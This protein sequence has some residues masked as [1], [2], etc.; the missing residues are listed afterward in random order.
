MQSHFRY[1]RR[2]DGIV[3]V[4]MDWPDS[5]V[6]LMDRQFNPALEALLT[7]LEAERE[8]T[9]GVI[10]TSAKTSFF[11]GADLKWLAGFE[12]DAAAEAFAL[13]ERTKALFRRIEL[14]GK[15]VVAVINGSALGAGWEIALACHHRVIV[16]SSDIRVGLPEVTLGLLPG[17]GGITRMVRLLGLEPA[18]PLLLEGKLLRPAE[19]TQ[20]GLATLARDYD[21]ALAQA[22]IYITAHHHATQPWDRKG[23]T[24]PGGTPSNPKVAQLAAI[25]PAM[26]TEKTRGAYPAPE[27]ILCTAVEGA[28]VD[29]A[30]AL[31]IESRALV[32][33]LTGQVAKNMIG[34]FFFQVN[35][36]KAEGRQL[37]D[38]RQRGKI[39]LGSDD[40]HDIFTLRLIHSYVSEAATMLAEGVPP[41]A[42]EHAALQAGFA[43]MPLA[44]L[45]EIGL[46]QALAAADQIRQAAETSD[47]PFSETPGAMLIRRM[48]QELGRT[49]KAAGV[50]FY[51]YPANGKQRL[52]PGL[53]MFGSGTLRAEPMDVSDLK[54]RLLYTQS[55]EAR[56]CLDEGILKNPRDANIDS[57]FR[58]GFPGWTGGAY[59]FIN[60]VG[61]ETFNRRAEELF[62]R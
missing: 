27:A 17:A 32:M 16:D 6:N 54:D 42:I 23:Y 29:F 44:L 4:T 59:Q 19:A 14:F 38:I 10:L 5:P 8:Q 45:D 62:K 49:G 56:R 3:T 61:R 57:I 28:Q 35:E 13:I 21:D 34:T 40:P 12:A 1:E 9:S 43:I 47:K 55:I 37:P 15:P 31:R 7:T 39:T 11:A 51:A 25:A 53:S 2:G 52:W 41:A 50:G 18:L 26:L 33:M 22:R 20:L 60:H 24:I 48:A 46:D 36:L 58:A 30:T